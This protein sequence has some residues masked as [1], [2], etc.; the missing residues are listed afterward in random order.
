[1]ALRDGG[2]NS[3]LGSVMTGCLG[4]SY[5]SLRVFCWTIKVSEEN[6]G[7]ICPIHTHSKITSASESP[8]TRMD[9]AMVVMFL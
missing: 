3:I 4:R 8:I 1:M 2:V 9:N 7:P 5:C 6:D